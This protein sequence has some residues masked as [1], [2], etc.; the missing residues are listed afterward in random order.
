MHLAR[1]HGFSQDL[2]FCKLQRIVYHEAEVMISDLP[3]RYPVLLLAV[4][5]ASPGGRRW[6]NPSGMGF[7]PLIK[8][9]VATSVSRKLRVLPWRKLECRDRLLHSQ[10]PDFLANRNGMTLYDLLEKMRISMPADPPV[11]AQW[12]GEYRHWD[13][14]LRSNHFPVSHQGAADKRGHIQ[15]GAVRSRS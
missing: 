1:Q 3:M 10:A 13:F 4:S 8:P 2:V 9:C 15:N 11:S 12:C 7:V 14:A 6:R 5:Y